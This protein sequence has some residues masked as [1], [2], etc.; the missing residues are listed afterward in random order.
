MLFHGSFSPKVLF[1]ANGSRV[2]F[3]IPFL[4]FL[5]GVSAT[6]ARKKVDVKSSGVED[7]RG[8]VE[9]LA[10]SGNHQPVAPKDDVQPRWFPV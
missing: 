2:V 8:D 3:L 5:S 4:R 1:A 10:L 6:A 9:L 7:H